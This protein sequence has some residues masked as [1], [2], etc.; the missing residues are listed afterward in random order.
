MSAPWHGTVTE[1]NGDEITVDLRRDGD[2]DMVAEVIAS[3]WGL[4]DAEPGD[5]LALDPEAG[6]VTRLDLGTWTQ[7]DL[8]EIARRAKEWH[9]QIMR[10]AS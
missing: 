2:M 4:E 8:D 9:A 3:R 6:T 5:V 10:C 1:V 7:E